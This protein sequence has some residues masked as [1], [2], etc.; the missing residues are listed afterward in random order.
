MTDTIVHLSPSNLNSWDELRKADEESPAWI[1]PESFKEGILGKFTP[2]VKASAG[3]AVHG[4]VFENHRF[5][6]ENGWKFNVGDE[7]EVFR[8][9]FPYGK[10]IPE[11]SKT[12]YFPD[13]IEGCLVR[14][15]QRADYLSQNMITEMKT[16]SR[17]FGTKGT[18]SG[19]LQSPQSF[20]YTWTWGI[21]I[22]FLF[23]EIAIKEHDGVN[24]ISLKKADHSTMYPCPESEQRLY[25]CVRTLIPYLKEDPEMWARVTGR[26]VQDEF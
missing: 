13:K 15:S 22:R 7:F 20:S 3:N 6:E 2:S 19:F 26:T 24:W 21:P 12:K 25:D 9:L 18:I 10:G 11:V 16:S 5:L 4:F 23:A 8:T 17:S 14:I 1:N